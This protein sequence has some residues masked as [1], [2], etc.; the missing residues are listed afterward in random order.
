MELAKTV[1]GIYVFD[2]EEL[3]DSE[4]FEESELPEVLEEEQPLEEEYSAADEVI[5]ST[6]RMSDISGIDEEQ[7]HELQREVARELTE[8]G[9]RESGDRDQLVVQAVRA[10]EDLDERNNE[11][12]ERLRPWYSLHFPELEEEISDNGEFAGTVAEDADRGDKEDYRSLAEGSTGMDITGRDAEIL[13]KLAGELEEGYRLREEVESYVQELAEEVAPNLSAVLG[14]VLA[15][16]VISLAGSLEKLAKMPSSTVQVLGAEKAMFRHVRG[17]GDAP[18][19]GVL[20]M[21]EYVR[22]VSQ[23]EQGKMARVLANK[24]S[25]AARL[26]QYGDD[27]RGDK[28]RGEVK[29]TFEEIKDG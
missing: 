15:A 28:L 9:I 26:D 29:E 17:E 13:E 16:R 25:I 24:A 1:T 11:L 21:H 22:K 7:I 4:K 23:E 10:L 12:S 19:H 20:F 6:E 27:Y 2:G 5:L 14:P 8:Q 18:K 3:V